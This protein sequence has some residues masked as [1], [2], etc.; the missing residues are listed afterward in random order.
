MWRYFSD[1]GNVMELSVFR[2]CENQYKNT[3]D[4]SH[5]ASSGGIV[6]VFDYLVWAYKL[7]D[8]AF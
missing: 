6:L 3:A 2:F 8:I 1:Y 5:I 4:F 7:K